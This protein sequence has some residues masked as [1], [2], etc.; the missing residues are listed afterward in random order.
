MTTVPAQARDRFRADTARA[1]EDVALQRALEN[2]G[3]GFIA[4]RQAA[5]QAVPEF[6]RLRDQARDI[7]NHTLA[8]L[9][10]YLQAFEDNVRASGGKVHW[11][12]DA[13]SA[14]AIVEDICRSHNVRRITKGKSMIC[15]E[16]GLNAHL[17]ARGFAVTETDL[18]EYII[19]LRGETPSHIIAPAI[20]VNRD[21][22]EEDFRRVHVHF[23]AGRDLSEPVQLLGEARR[24]LRERFLD[25]DAGITGAN[26]LVAETG[27][28]VI[29][30]NEGNGDLT[31]TLPNVHIVVASLE[32]IVPTLNDC[33][34]LL[35]LLARSATGQAMAA[36]TT[37][38]T[39]PKRAGDGDGP[40]HFHVILLDNGRSS[41]LGTQFQDVLRCI[42][43][44]ACMNHCPVYQAIGGHAY[45]STYPGPIGAVLTPTIKG[46]K[47]SA[48]LPGA[49]TFCGACEA[50]CPVRI[51]LPHLMRNWRS[52][53]FRNHYC[54][55]T[56]RFALG[57]WAVF[58]TRPWLYRLATRVAMAILGGLGR[59]RGRFASVPF[60]RG[61]T[62][63]R[64]L[65]APEGE[66][67]MALWKKR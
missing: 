2:V 11:A 19:Q 8:H 52:E 58:A 46:I 23:D 31:Q 13:G 42:R 32:K 49:S 34:Q 30:T 41:V 45:G 62:D 14:C 25:A 54:P 26:F 59:K 27:S 18:G 16:M 29:V 47:T 33:S 22:I 3:K 63:Y 43:C 65:P 55:A 15:E 35:R 5:A 39:G 38:S 36:Y 28:V 61:W 64:D 10:L 7:K 53:A 67:F 44:G 12:T 51:P 24:V 60:A 57:L 66:T 6:E 37:F 50:V 1:L 21:Q 56:E 9:D 4:R 40:E 20:H 48:H 17:E